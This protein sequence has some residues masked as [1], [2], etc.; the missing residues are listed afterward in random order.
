MKCSICDSEMDLD[1]RG[2]IAGE[3]G[4]LP[5]Q[6]CEWCLASIIDMFR[7]LECDDCEYKPEGDNHG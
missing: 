5:V 7:Q 4:I 1:G 6:F 3:F 2:G